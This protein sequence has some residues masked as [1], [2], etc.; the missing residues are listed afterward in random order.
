MASCRD[1][2]QCAEQLKRRLH[3]SI[4]LQF[5]CCSVLS[6]RRARLRLPSLPHHGPQKFLRVCQHLVRVR[7]LLAVH[8]DGIVSER[9]S[10]I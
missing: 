1:G 8:A 10:P 7:R 6:S 4:S 9:R 2:C 5:G 3:T